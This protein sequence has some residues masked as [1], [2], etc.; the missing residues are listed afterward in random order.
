MS[1]WDM[2]SP[3]VLQEHCLIGIA[4]PLQNNFS[5]VETPFVQSNPSK[6][7]H[8]WWSTD[9]LNTLPQERAASTTEQLPIKGL[10]RKKILPQF[11]LHLC[12]PLLPYYCGHIK[13]P[14]EPRTDPTP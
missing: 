11:P 1:I 6:E 5:M 4:R 14:K 7:P 10:Q 2:D 8:L 3:Y 12:P 13:L 9:L